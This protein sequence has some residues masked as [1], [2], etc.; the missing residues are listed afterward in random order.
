[1]R[2]FLAEVKAFRMKRTP[3]HL[4]F[5]GTGVVPVSLLLWLNHALAWVHATS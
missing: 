5:L 1:M 2:G 4:G 3:S